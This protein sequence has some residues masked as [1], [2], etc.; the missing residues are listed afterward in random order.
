MNFQ[1][2]NLEVAQ[3]VATVTINRPDKG[4]ALA[5]DVL[6]EVTHM[7]NALGV[8]QDVNVIVFTGGERYF[9]AG[10]DLNEIRKLEK[11]KQRGVHRP[12]SSGVPR[13]F[14]LRA[15]RDLRCGRCCHCRWI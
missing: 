1:Y 10:F 7:F 12:V 11:D 2:L 5:P 14:I 9:S 15:T 3:R 4:N 13:Y 8:R 6:D